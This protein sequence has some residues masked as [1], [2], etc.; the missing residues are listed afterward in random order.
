M[1]GDIVYVDYERSSWKFMNYERF[2]RHEDLDS[3]KISGQPALSHDTIN[4]FID[5]PFTK[6]GGS[7][8]GGQ[9]R[10]NPNKPA[11]QRYVGT[12]GEVKT[13]VIL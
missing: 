2:D 12:P 5:I 1:Q 6:G 9:W 7:A 8:F 11:D 10:P 13:T 3:F 4:T